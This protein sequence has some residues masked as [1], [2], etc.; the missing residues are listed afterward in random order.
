MAEG[1]EA[2]WRLRGGWEVRQARAE[3]GGE[4]EARSHESILER[5]GGR[6]EVAPTVGTDLLRVI[7]S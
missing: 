3:G 4:D 2:E 5:A 1:G 7:G 6:W